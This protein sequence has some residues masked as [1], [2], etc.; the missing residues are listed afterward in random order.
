MQRKMYRAFGF[1]VYNNIFKDA[2]PYFPAYAA[3]RKWFNYFTKGSMVNNVVMSTNEAL[4]DWPTGSWITPD[5]LTFSGT[6]SHTIVGDTEVWCV[7]AEANNNYLPDCEKWF[8]SAG[9][10]ETLPVGTKI[11]FCDGSL[12]VNGQT[13]TNPTQLKIKSS[14]TTVTANQDCFGIKFV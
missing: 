9:S 7:P 14:D 8:L 11:M 4:P 1:L 2:E 5:D 6:V 13:I 10:S 12:A 3:N